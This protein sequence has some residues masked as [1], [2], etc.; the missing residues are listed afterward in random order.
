[1]ESLS[2]RRILMVLAHDQYRDEE[3]GEPR[4]V[5]ENEGAK[6]AIASSSLGEARGKL[7]GRAAVDILLDEV[8]GEDYEAVVFVGG[9]GSSEYFR[10]SKALSLVKEAFDAGKVIAAICIAPVTLANAGILKGKRA[11]AFPSVESDLKAQGVNYT[12]NS[13]ERDG[14]IITGRGPE[15]ATEFGRMVVAALQDLKKI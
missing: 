1:M 6:V 13:V 3:Y 9:P 11:T 2:G 14:R 10:N 5:F 8:R 7:G 4:K 12:G 15:A